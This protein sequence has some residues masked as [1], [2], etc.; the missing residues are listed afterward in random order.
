MAVCDDIIFSAAKEADKHLAEK[1]RADVLYYNGPVSMQCFSWF[2]ETVEKM[3]V[4]ADK[5]PGIAVF[6][7]Y[8]RRPGGSGREV[9]RYFTP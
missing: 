6:F 2:R 1:L 5:K 4:C 8:G 7:N 9:C 3:A